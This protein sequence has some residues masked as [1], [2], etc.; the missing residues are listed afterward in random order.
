MKTLDLADVG[1]AG[2]LDME[3]TA[4]GV[5]LR[6]LPDWTR[7]QLVDPGLSLLVTMPAG[8]RIELETDTTELELEVMLTRLTVEPAEASPAGFD[9][10]VDGDVVASRQSQAGRVIKFD[11]ATQRLDLVPGDPTTIHFGELLGCAGSRVEVWLPHTAVVELRAVRVSNGA[12]ATPVFWSDRPR[13]VHYGSSVSHCFE[14]D[15][16]TGTWP[17]VTARLMGLDLQNLA[18]AGNCMLDQHVARTIRDLDAA[19]IS[20]KVGVNIVGDDTMRERT[21]IPALHG[22]LD[23]VRDGH[24]TTPIAVVTPIYAPVT[25]NHPG[26]MVT[27]ADGRPAVVERQPELAT[28]SLTIRRVRELIAA[29]VE[30]RR[31]YGDA[32]LHLLD[33]LALFGPDDVDDLP[34]LLHPSAAGYQRMGERFAAMAFAPGRPLERH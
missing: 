23:T 16:P 4:D 14:A 30:A 18:V 9:L 29:V 7:H 32:N 20:L 33:G 1:I 25:E 26:P 27:G 2:V 17:A 8:A 28:G 10:V 22:F 15:R 3:R 34:D 5:V 6:R 12:S 24:P 31:E 21:F 13:W 11:P 19:A